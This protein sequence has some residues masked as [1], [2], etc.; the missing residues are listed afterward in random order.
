MQ[1]NSERCYTF[2]FRTIIKNVG[3]QV[4]STFLTQCV[5]SVANVENHTTRNLTW[6][7]I[8]DKSVILFR[9]TDV[10]SVWRRFDTITASSGI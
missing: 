5:S 1:I 2:N 10:P 6:I 7:A 3:F 4:E 9:S 8:G